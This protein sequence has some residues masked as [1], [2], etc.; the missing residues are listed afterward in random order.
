VKFPVSSNVV[1][2]P[3][4]SLI[5]FNYHSLIRNHNHHADFQGGIYAFNARAAGDVCIAHFLRTR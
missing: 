5:S 4:S 3:T 2:L 1:A